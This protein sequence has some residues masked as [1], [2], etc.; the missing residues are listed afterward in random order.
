MVKKP[1]AINDLVKNFGSAP[2]VARIVSYD[3]FVLALVVAIKR[4]APILHGGLVKL[5]PI[6]PVVIPNLP[7]ILGVLIGF[8]FGVNLHVNLLSWT[9]VNQIAQLFT[10]TT[11]S[12]NVAENFRS[13]FYVNYQ[14]FVQEF[15]RTYINYLEGSDPE[16]TSTALVPYTRQVPFNKDVFV[17]TSPGLTLYYQEDLD[18]Q[19]SKFS[20]TTLEGYYRKTKNL[21]GDTTIQWF[22]NRKKRNLKPSYIPLKSRTKTLAD[23]INSDSKSERNSAPRIITSLQNKQIRENLILEFLE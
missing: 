19:T 10:T 5:N 12:Y 17:S 22:S 13:Q 11:I 1:K 16:K 23:I 9:L 2:E 21:S 8:G 20:V 18:Q 4:F 15:S 14:N 6:P 3:V 7:L